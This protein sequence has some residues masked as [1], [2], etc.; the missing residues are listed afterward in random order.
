MISKESFL[1]QASEAYDKWA[2]QHPDKKNA[3]DYEKDFEAWFI[4]FGRQI[5]SESATEL[6]KNRNQKKKS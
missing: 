1:A 5:L 4:E 6:P 3:Y 2:G